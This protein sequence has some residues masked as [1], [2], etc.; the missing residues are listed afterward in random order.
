MPSDPPPPPRP[1][2][3]EPGQAEA[4]GA[5]IEQYETGAR[6]RAG[7]GGALITGLAAGW[8]LF[9]LAI[10]RHLLLNHIGKHS[11]KVR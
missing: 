3:D 5:L 11:L 1:T 8:S 6:R 9:Q 7:F 10:A 4:A 2:R